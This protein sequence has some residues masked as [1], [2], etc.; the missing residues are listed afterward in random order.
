MPLIPVLRRQRKEEFEDSLVYR[1]SPRAA[2]AIQ[3]N[4]VLKNRKKKKKKK[5]FVCKLCKHETP[6]I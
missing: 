6:N 5:G 1:V 4:P 2:S 3:R